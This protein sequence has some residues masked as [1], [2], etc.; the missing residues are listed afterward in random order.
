MEKNKPPLRIISPGR[1]YR[2]EDISVKSY[3]LFHQIE[4]LYV[5]KNVSFADL[6]STLDYF[7]KMMFGQDVRVRFRPS[8]FPF[9]EPSAEM[10]IYWGL[11]TESDYKVTKGTGWLEILG[12]GMVDPNVFESVKFDSSKWRGYAFGM[13]IERIAMIKYGISDIRK[14]YDGNVKFLEQFKI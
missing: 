6:K 9:T 1:V 11:K 13:G 4:G 3:C 8:F 10:D 5:D 7:A 2:N 14:F 12:C